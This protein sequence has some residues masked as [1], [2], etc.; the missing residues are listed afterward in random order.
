MAKKQI[1]QAL[2]GR[3]V[4]LQYLDNL[5]RVARRENMPDD[6]ILEVVYDENFRRTFLVIQAEV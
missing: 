2:E 5:V 4:T 1:R 3:A 6:S